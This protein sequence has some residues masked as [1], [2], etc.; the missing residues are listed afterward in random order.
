[1]TLKM[2]HFNCEVVRACDPKTWSW[3]RQEDL[4]EFKVILGHI[5]NLAPP[6][7]K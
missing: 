5:A 1:M 4:G 3:W 2:N 6:W 7:A